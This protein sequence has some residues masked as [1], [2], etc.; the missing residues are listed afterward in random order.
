LISTT[1]LGGER[2]GAL[3]EEGGA[4]HHHRR[5]SNIPIGDFDL[6]IGALMLLIRPP[7]M[8]VLTTCA[9]NLAV[10][11]WQEKS[12]NGE[13]CANKRRCVRQRT[14][15][16]GTIV[17]STSPRTAFLSLC[18]SLRVYADAA[19]ALLNRGDHG[20]VDFALCLLLIHEAPWVSQWPMVTPGVEN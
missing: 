20:Q 7:F 3:Q 16:T 9:D 2:R 10:L 15:Q 12:T 19:R 1:Y 6:L 14:D 4:G 8:L 11:S 13:I 17:D 18:S 5:M